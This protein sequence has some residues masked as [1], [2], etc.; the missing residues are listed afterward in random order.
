MAFTGVGDGKG[1]TDLI[2]F[3][4][5]LEEAHVAPFSLSLVQVYLRVSVLWVGPD[6]VEEVVVLRGED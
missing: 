2:P 1:G 6:R 5:L 3:K 4:G